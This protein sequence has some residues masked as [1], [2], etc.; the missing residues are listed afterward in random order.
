MFK[1]DL[2]IGL[3][4]EKEVCEMLETLFDI[5]RSVGS[6]KDKDLEISGKVEIKY[7]RQAVKTGNIALE[8]RCRNQLSGLS[9]TKSKAWIICTDEGCW[10][11]PLKS[12]RHWAKE[13]ATKINDWDSLT[14]GGDDGLSEFSLIDYRL[15]KSYIKIL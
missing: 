5:K 11:C 14:K 1:E 12:L 2:E 13:Y 4:K 7:D 9:T 8:V 6:D 10:I 3:K 15:I